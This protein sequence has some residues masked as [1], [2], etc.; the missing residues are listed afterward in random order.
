MDVLERIRRLID[1]A[2]KDM[3]SN[4]ARNAA[5]QAC[6]LIRENNLEIRDPNQRNGKDLRVVASATFQSL[7][8]QFLRSFFRDAG[9]DHATI[10]AAV[11]RYISDQEPRGCTCDEI[12]ENLGL[13]HQTVSPRVH[14]LVNEKKVRRMVQTGITRSGGKARL[15]RLYRSKKKDTS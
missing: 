11:L 1:L 13:S 14:D 15:L 2:V 7:D 6:R 3:E 5:I 9:L 4:E 10:K 12:E 8:E